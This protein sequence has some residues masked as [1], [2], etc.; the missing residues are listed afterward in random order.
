M[1]RGKYI[2][3]IAFLIF[4]FTTAGIGRTRNDNQPVPYKYLNIYTVTSLNGQTD[5]AYITD[6]SKDYETLLKFFKK[7]KDKMDK[8]EFIRLVYSKVQEVFLLHYKQYAGFS[9]IF[10]D[11][12][13][14][15]VTATA[16]Y[17]SFFSD[18]NID[19]EIWETNYHSYLKLET[20]Q[21]VV[22]LESTDPIEGI[23]KGADLELLEIE[24]LN[25]NQ[26]GYLFENGINIYKKT[27]PEELTGLLYFNQAVRSF[28]EKN[29]LR[30]FQYILDADMYYPSE[31]IDLLKDIIEDTVLLASI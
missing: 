24:Y 20:G 21:E 5:P 3:L 6:L 11:Y 31:R 17:V 23:K 29:Y 15:C 26:Q 4:S 10:T 18:L 13:Y 19:F 12:T 9:E 16:L 30:S 28:N 22:L 7:R 14:D 2:S 8:E 1:S 27:T 25:D